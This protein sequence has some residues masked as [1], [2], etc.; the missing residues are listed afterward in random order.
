MVGFK[1]YGI[2]AQAAYADH[3]YVKGF[4]YLLEIRNL[5]ASTM[6]LVDVQHEE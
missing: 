5:G 3:S 4:L 2:H 1:S 6:L